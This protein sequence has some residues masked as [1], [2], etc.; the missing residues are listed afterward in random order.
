M[1]QYLCH[2]S[3]QETGDLLPGTITHGS[4]FN[5]LIAKNSRH[6]FFHPVSH[7][8]FQN[9]ATVQVISRE[10]CLF[11]CLVSSLGAHAQDLTGWVEQMAPASAI[12]AISIEFEYTGLI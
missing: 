6:H 4:N 2:H 10:M 8:H 3:G 1:H 11:E 12:L 7:P 5:I 9:S